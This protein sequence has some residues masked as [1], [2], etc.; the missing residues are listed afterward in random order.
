VLHRAIPRW[1]TYKEL[2]AAFREETEIAS[3][4]RADFEKAMLDV[5]IGFECGR[6]KFDLNAS[7]SRVSDSLAYLDACFQEEDVERGREFLERRFFV[8]LCRA[9]QV[10][11][12]ELKPTEALWL[13]L[14]DPI[15]TDIKP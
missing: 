13:G 10:R 3:V 9:L 15:R 12:N 5:C 6:D 7:P 4:S 14:L 11:E 2:L 8:T 1:E